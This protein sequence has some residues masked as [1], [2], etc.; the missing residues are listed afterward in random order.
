MFTVLH[1]FADMQ[2]NG[3]VYRVGDVFPRAGYEP[4]ADRLAVLQS[5]SNRLGEPLISRVSKTMPD[6]EKADT[7]AESGETGQDS[8]PKRR[9]KKKAAE[10][11]E[12]AV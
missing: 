11:E 6:E 9:G 4:G 3:H 12:E 5:N 8:A 7:K 2:D 1:E 10:G